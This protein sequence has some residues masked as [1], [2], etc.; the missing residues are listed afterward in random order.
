MSLKSILESLFPFLF[1]AAAKTFDK[2]ED[3]AKEAGINGSLLSQIIK[4]NLDA[5][6]EDIRKQFIKLTGLDE[7]TVASVFEQIG[8]KYG[9]SDGTIISYLQS[10]FKSAVS[11]EKFNSIANEVGVIAG[12]VLSGGKLT[13]LSLLAGL[14]E[15]IYRKFVK[16][17]DVVI[18]MA[19]P[20]VTDPT[21]PGHGGKP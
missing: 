18:A 21:T 20:P 15:Y 14:A 13:W 3:A 1:S 5:A 2:L 9:I 11:D 17:K 8:E 19:T 10:L 12:I 6:E 7:I 4:D 16:G